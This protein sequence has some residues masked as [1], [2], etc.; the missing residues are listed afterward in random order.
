MACITSLPAFCGVVGRVHVL[1]CGFVVCDL[2][3]RIE[4]LLCSGKGLSTG[5]PA[6]FSHALLNDFRFASLN[7]KI[8]LE[9]CHFFFLWITVLSNEIAGV[10]GVLS[11]LVLRVIS[12][13]FMGVSLCFHDHFRDST[14]MVK[15][16]NCNGFEVWA[17]SAQLVCLRPPFRP[18]TSWSTM[19]TSLPLAQQIFLDDAPK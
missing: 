14:K 2:G 10:S 9:K 18:D 17:R 6:D 5:E 4:F 3:I 19:P 15:A 12:S 16:N 11:S 7:G 1:L 8:A 13:R